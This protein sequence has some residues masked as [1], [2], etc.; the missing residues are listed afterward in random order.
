MRI[1]SFTTRGIDEDEADEATD[2]GTDVDMGAEDAPG[3]GEV[4]AAFEVREAAIGGEAAAAAAEEAACATT[5][6][7]AS[8]IGF[9]LSG[10]HLLR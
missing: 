3:G 5:S 1:P 2:F 7:S 9:R 8:L 6:M 10:S 4:E